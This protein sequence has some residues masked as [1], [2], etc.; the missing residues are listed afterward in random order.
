[1][2][3]ELARP[4]EWLSRAGPG[5]VYERKLDG[6]RCIAVRNGDEV[7]LW[8][9]NHNSFTQRFPAVADALAKQK[10]PTFTLDGEVVAFDGK[11]FV[12]FGALQEHGRTLPVVYCVFDLLFLLGEDTTGLVVPD[13]K[14]LLRQAIDPDEN[15][16]IVLELDGDPSKLLEEAC[17]KGW[18]GLIAKRI[19]SKYE[20]GRSPAWRKLKCSASQELVIAGWTDPQRSRTGFGALLVG[21]NEGDRLRYAGKVGTGFSEATLRELHAELIKRE[22]ET[23]PFDDP[24]KEKGA[25]W[26]RPELVANIAFT[27]WTRDGRLRH[28][29]FEGLRPDKTAKEVVRERPTS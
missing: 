2:L 10:T 19:D 11:D 3:A 15:V 29:R 13:R 28:P 1:M 21:Y 17:A 25:H 16:Q 18:E 23:S 6:L 8:S 4:A 9:R 24:V 14:K 27:E 22:I 7:D 26:A 12:G 5:W 20:A